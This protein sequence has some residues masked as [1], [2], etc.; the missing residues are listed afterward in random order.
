MKKNLVTADAAAR[1]FELGAQLGQV[2]REAAAAETAILQELRTILPPSVDKP[3]SDGDRLLMQ[4]SAA[5]APTRR[6]RKTGKRSGPTVG[7]R[8]LTLLKTGIGPGEIAKKL[9][10]SPNHA[11]TT[12]ATLVKK[13]LAKPLGGGKYQVL[14]RDAF[15]NARLKP[16]K[17]AKRAKKS[18]GKK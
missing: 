18:K 13:K 8:V 3:L 9:G 4:Q 15:S 1:A 16:R 5:E 7:E 12:I 11:S 10:I 17:A 14:V 2:R 6:G